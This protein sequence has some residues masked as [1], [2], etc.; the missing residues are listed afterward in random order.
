M[1]D[2]VRAIAKRA[3][4]AACLSLAVA[5]GADAQQPL[6]RTP[7]ATKQ[8]LPRYDFHLEAEA[9]SGQDERFTWDTHWGG[10]FDV[11]DYVRGRL[12]LLADYQAVLGSELQPFD[13]NQSTYTLEVSSSFR[14]GWAEIAGMLHHESRHLGDRSKEFGIAQNVV[15]GRVMGYLE[16]RRASLALRVDGGKITNRSTFI[17]YTWTASCEALVR[18]SVTPRV[19]LFGRALGEFFLVDPTVAGRERQHGGRLEAGIRMAGESG[20]LELFGGYARVIDADLLD[21]QA[22]TWAFAGFRIANR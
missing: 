11:V 10:D 3:A 17:D 15:G 14:V 22:A 13:P 12:T 7:A 2:A 4:I 9:L 19:G 5:G 21:R 20:A 8:F 6:S 18:Q 16:A 1:P